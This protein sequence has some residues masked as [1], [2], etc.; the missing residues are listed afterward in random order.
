MKIGILTFHDGI[1]HGGF[2]QAYF[3][4]QYLLSIGQN[5]E[6]INYKNDLH[7][8]NE[9]KAFLITK[10]PSRLVRNIIKIINFRIDQKLLKAWP[11]RLIT[12]PECLKNITK[13]YN[14]IIVGSDV[15][16]DYEFKFTGNDPVYFGYYLYPTHGLISY[17]ASMGRSSCRPPEYVINGLKKFN[18]ISVRDDNTK[19]IVERYTGIDAIKVVDPT[20]LLNLGELRIGNKMN[21]KFKEIGDYILLYAYYFPDSWKIAIQEFANKYDLAIVV[22]GYPQNIKS[23]NKI[24]IGPVAWLEAF[25]FAKY[26]VTSTF[27]GTIFSILTNKP[28]VTIAN[29]AIDNKAGTLLR[30]FGLENRYLDTGFNEFY[31]FDDLNSL[32]IMEKLEKYRLNAKHYLAMALQI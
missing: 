25:Q 20:L 18:K 1:N 26:I 28:F 14:Y 27:H 31:F 19:E 23:I 9:Y 16:W 5:V 11:R 4:Q 24:H 6:I 21:S 12:K 29:S 17:A 10:N 22:I 8:L 32:E 13:R 15:I 7:W 30:D 3:L 2:Y